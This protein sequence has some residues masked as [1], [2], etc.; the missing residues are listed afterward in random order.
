MQNSSSDLRVGFSDVVRS[1]LCL[2]APDRGL[3]VIV[4]AMLGGG[5]FRPIV[6][7]G[8]MRSSMWLFDQIP[9][10]TADVS[11]VCVLAY[12]HGFQITIDSLPENIYQATVCDPVSGATKTLAG[13]V[14][15]G[16]ALVALIASLRV[17]GS[18]SPSTAAA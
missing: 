18:L 2:T 7:A 5:S 8:D 3:D 15:A 10:Y 16:V 13:R 9:H 17:R 12:R 14:S 6:S 4:H 1:L 11:A